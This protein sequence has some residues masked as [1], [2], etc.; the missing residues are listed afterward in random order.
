MNF[1]NHV[2]LQQNNIVNIVLDPRATPPAGGV[3]GQ[4]YYNTSNDIVY[5]HDGTEWVPLG[6][7]NVESEDGSI[8]ITQS[9]GNVDLGVNV[10]DASIEISAE[11]E[12]RIKDLGVT[13]PKL[14]DG[15][16]TTIKV[17]DGAI[18]F[19]KIQDLPTMTVI[20]RVAS[21]TG[22]ASA[23]T[24]INDNELTDA[25][26]TNLATAGAI[27]AYVD[28][29]ISGIGTLIGSFNANTSTQFPGTSDTKKGDYWYVSVAG[30]V[31]GVPLNVGDVL[32]AN[33]ED[34]SPTDPND[35]IF[36][37]TN[38]DQ[39][40]TTMLGVVMLATN[41]EVQAG[42]NNTKAV[43]PAGLESRTSTET[44][45]GLARIA[46]EQEA[47]E[48]ED[49]TTIMTPAKVKAVL[50]ST[51]GG[52]STIFGDGANSTFEIEH[53]LGTENIVV[54]LYYVSGGGAFIT[55]Y[56]VISANS[57]RVTFSQPPSNNSVRI[58]IK[59]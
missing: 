55:D 8:N 12:V 34:P 14:A 56:F 36:L 19:S 23:I 30:T 44:R 21:G 45:T 16:V 26:G 5:K 15:A 53:E 10:D 59:K 4:L 3:K 51:V 25:D 9:D 50:D 20:G 13:T 40:T 28:A 1:E 2:D 48:G 57:V 6:F 17:T 43:T 58:V 24:I 39:A 18:T 35:W 32:I 38:R 52:F 54:N 49:D 47:I 37:E 46:T 27:K 22:E 41:A 29:L 42:V 11:G 33:V 31:Q 7:V